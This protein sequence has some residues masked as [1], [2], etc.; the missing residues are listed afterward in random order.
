[1][2]ITY[3]E[4]S[5]FLLE[6]EDVDFLFDYYKGNIPH[7]VKEKPLVVFVSHSHYDH[8]N[9]VVFDLLKEYPNTRYVLSD[10]VIVGKEVKQCIKVA[11]DEK[12]QISVLSDGENLSIET[13][14][15]TDEGVAFLLE[16]KG[17]TIYHAGDLNLWVWEGESSQ[18]NEEMTRDYFAELE[19]LKGRTIDIAFV[20]LDPRQEKGAFGGLES[21]LEYTNSKHV[22][23]MHFWGNY[24]IVEEFLNSHPEYEKVIKRISYVGQSFEI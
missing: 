12:L 23:P 13:F 11:A 7:R 4:H 9:P 6:M 20:P 21:F 15:S 2:K 14:K 18:Y 17:R 1:M 24:G 10:D 22:F 16:Y 19:K 5:G 3:I 8:Y